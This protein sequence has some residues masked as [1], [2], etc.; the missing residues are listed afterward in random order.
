MCCSTSPWSRD[1]PKLKVI[2]A[3]TLMSGTFGREPGARSTFKNQAGNGQGCV[4]GETRVAQ[5][6]Q[7][8]LTL[9]QRGQGRG[10]REV[11][12]VQW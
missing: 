7:G 12:R 2:P 11:P 6:L 4:V 8:R 1:T 3:V 10:R 9:R 5:D